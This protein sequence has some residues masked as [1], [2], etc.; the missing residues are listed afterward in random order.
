MKYIS[1]LILSI[2]I[3]FVSCR[4]SDDKPV[5]DKYEG[6]FRVESEEEAKIIYSALGY[7]QKSDFKAISVTSHKVLSLKNGD[8]FYFIELA[9]ARS[10][11]L[12]FA[13]QF[14]GIYNGAERDLQNVVLISCD[15]TG[16]C[17]DCRLALQGNCGVMSCSCSQSGSG[18]YDCELSFNE[19]STFADNF[20]AKGKEFS[21][22]IKIPKLEHLY[23]EQY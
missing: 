4:E 9:D 10:Q 11:I 16:S 14:A 13:F 19:I 17:D 8:K 15:N 6:G 7:V 12:T 5:S 22:N 2:L 20:N 21:K 23:C 18:A 1:F 3:L